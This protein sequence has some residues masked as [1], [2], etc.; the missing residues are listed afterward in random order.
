LFSY[1]LFGKMAQ[2]VLRE[3]AIHEPYC[4]N[5]F[6]RATAIYGFADGVLALESFTS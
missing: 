1:A 3:G 5:K 4:A 2:I 6:V